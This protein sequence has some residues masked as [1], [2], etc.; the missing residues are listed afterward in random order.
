LA[1]ETVDF[2]DGF[3]NAHPEFRRV[4]TADVLEQQRIALPPDWGAYTAQGDLLLWPH[5]TGTDGFY[6]AVMARGLL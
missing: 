4:S 3:L 1:A 6:A 2:V 5:R